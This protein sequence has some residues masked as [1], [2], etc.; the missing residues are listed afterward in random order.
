MLVGQVEHAAQHASVRI[1]DG[2]FD[3]ELRVSR[4]VRGG[5]QHRAVVHHQ[6]QV[7][8]C[9]G[10]ARTT[11][12][13]SRRRRARHRTKSA[14]IL[15]GEGAPQG[16]RAPS[17]QEQAASGLVHL[18]LVDDAH[19]AEVPIL[20]ALALGFALPPLLGT[21]GARV[22]QHRDAQHGQDAT[23]D[24]QPEGHRALLSI[25]V[26]LVQ[27]FADATSAGRACSRTTPPQP[28]AWAGRPTRYRVGLVRSL[29]PASSG[30]LEH[31]RPATRSMPGRHAAWCAV[32][33]HR[34]CRAE[35]P[36]VPRRSPCGSL[37]TVLTAS[38]PV[39][40]LALRWRWPLRLR[41]PVAVPEWTPPASGARS[42]TR[43]SSLEP[44]QQPRPW[45][46]SRR[47]AALPG[48]SAQRRA[49]RPARR[50]A[51]HATA[52]GTPA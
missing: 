38:H 19:A 36:R 40:A 52:R 6:A 7:H 41:Q 26:H 22:G 34:A 44:R 18:A 13:R 50:G 43:S 17:D 47:R 29:R 20:R 33:L 48:G 35:S 21:R 46:Q 30:G 51:L 2:V 3:D 31:S 5:H 27:P 42:T 16:E 14:F 24:H 1:P 23:G 25:L 15:R 4:G 9:A 8:C 10:A 11:G 37:H 32:L 39:R 28:D 12:D 45:R 49:A